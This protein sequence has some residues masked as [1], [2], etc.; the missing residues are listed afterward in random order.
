MLINKKLF[1]GTFAVL[2]P[3]IFFVLT[4]I[5]LIS[6]S[7]STSGTIDQ[8]WAIRIYI[9]F[10][11]MFSSLVLIIQLLKVQ[12]FSYKPYIS[13]SLSHHHDK[14][15]E[16]HELKLKGYSFCTGCVGTSIGLIFSQIII[17]TFVYFRTS[18]L[19]LN[20]ILVIIGF[21]LIYFAY[22]RYLIEFRPLFRLFQHSFLPIGATLLVLNID[23]VYESALGL[24]FM[25]F[26]TITILVNRNI[27]SMIFHS[28]QLK[29]TLE[30]D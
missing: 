6:L 10:M 20:Q 9:L 24:I 2:N 7:S 15:K 1:F 3:I 25:F 21:L 28:M 19:E 11:F 18:F 27:I 13:L 22:S 5:L 8:L 30:S 12:L 23:L 26:T 4:K 29:R 17:F 16:S 14:V